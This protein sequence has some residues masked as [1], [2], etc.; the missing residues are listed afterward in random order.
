MKFYRYLLALSFLFI[1]FCTIQ[2]QNNVGVG[3]ISPDVSAVLDVSSST[4]GMLVPRLTTLQ[5]LAISNPATSLLVYDVNFECFYYFKS[6]SSTWQ[7][8]CETNFD[9]LF[10]N[11]ATIDTIWANVIYADTII[12]GVSN[13]DTLYIGNV[14]IDTV[15]GEA[16][17]KNAWLLLG[18]LNT[19]PAINFLGTIDNV[20]LVFRT[21]NI[22]KM[23][24]LNNGQGG[25]GTSLPHPTAIFEISDTTKGF[26]PP[27]LSLNQRNGIS[28]P[29][30]GL[31][32]FNTTDSVMQYW[33]GQCW[34]AT[35][36]EDCN[37]CFFNMSLS[38][39]AGTIDRT[40]TDTAGTDIT[41]NQ[42]SG[43]NQQIGI[44]L[45]HNLP[46]GVTANLT[47]GTV[48][49]NGTTHLTI[50]ASIFASPG[51]FPV[52]VQAICGNT[53]HTQ[54]FTVTIDTCITVNINSN[55]TD[56]DLAA[57][58]NLPGP[59]TRICV[60]VN[61]APGVEVVSDSTIYSAFT[62]GNLDPQSHVGILNS[63]AILGR[64]GNGGDIAGSS[65][66][67]Q[68]GYNGGD[69]ITLSCQTTLQ[70]NFGYIFAGGGG[71]SSIGA[72]FPINTPVGN[73]SF[74]I[75]AGGG[76]G[77]NAGYGGDPNAVL[78]TF[79]GGSDATSGVTS[80]P[81]QGGVLN[82]PINIPISIVTLSINPQIYG[83]DGGA[84]GQPG[85]A[86]SFILNI[87][88]S[89]SIPFIGTITIPIPIGNIPVPV[90]PGGQ[91]GLVVKRNGY[92][93]NGYPDGPYNTLFIKG[94]IAP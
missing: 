25:F 55:V 50:Q 61:I 83:G 74:A 66:F 15:I 31:M 21:N 33:N 76:G 37:Q 78:N 73:F 22:E 59:G 29:A 41:I 5:R 43:T 63:G 80:V 36:Q 84:Y 11:I 44:F 12:S 6:G 56:Y 58:N 45:I 88:A 46:Q 52:A 20:D 1:G 51:V 60:V 10:V 24:I 57:I 17:S 18:N 92:V 49:G 13:I 77:S 85:T 42:T 26:L 79:A 54:I 89:F 40:L 9:S 71:G 23:R 4:K 3:T 30:S 93:L 39:S 64:G 34:L 82:V 47:S 69:A 28:N 90:L 81:G 14:P 35:Y 86:G 38:A 8:M 53:I 70:N 16:V 19:N 87:S 72:G 65:T 91:P 75:G 7:S 94:S 68:A 62:S 48:N 2:A 27:R 67:S 32:I